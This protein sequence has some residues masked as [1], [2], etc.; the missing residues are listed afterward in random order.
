MLWGQ[1]ER[2]ELASDNLELKPLSEALRLARS[3]LL[4]I[5]PLA[6]RVQWGQDERG[7]EIRTKKPRIS[8][9]L[10]WVDFGILS[11]TEEA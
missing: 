6:Q 5:P 9:A 7:G 11:V 8:E 2:I 1:D 3:S 4:S 10:H